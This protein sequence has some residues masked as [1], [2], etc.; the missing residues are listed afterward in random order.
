[1]ELQ[2]L[3]TLALLTIALLTGCTSVF[4]QPSRVRYPYLEVD[5]L[6]AKT[7]TLISKDGTK[8]SAWAIDSVQSRKNHP[9]IA[10]PKDLAANEKR[11]IALQ[12]HGNAENMTS[13]YRFQ[14]WLL[15]EGWDVLTFDYRGY[16]MSA[17]DT[18][19]LDGVRDDG[20]AAIEWANKIAKE[21][22]LPLVIFGQSLGANI[23]VS[24]M[25]EMNPDRLKLFVVDSSFYSFTSIAREKLSDVWFLWPFQWLGWLLVSD[26][27]S[28]GPKLENLTP[29]T[30]GAFKTPAIFLHSLNDPIVSNRQGEKLYGVYP[31]EKIRWTTA[32][33]GHVNTLFAEPNKDVPPKTV[34]REKLK[35]RLRELQGSWFEPTSE[36][37]RA[38]K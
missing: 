32:E 8:L 13:H 22:N 29:T 36:K 33:P 2:S 5:E 4:F 9:E 20:V 19:N 1:M 26:E 38:S 14:L 34:Y 10:T 12:F 37:P 17:G 3:P 31:S 21:K 35:V 25:K 6:S 23:A 18:S 15:F 11:G 7:E 27:L 24:A 16:G 28:A 30:L